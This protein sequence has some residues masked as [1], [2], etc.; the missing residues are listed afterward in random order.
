MTSPHIVENIN[1]SLSFAEGFINHISTSSGEDVQLSFTS[2]EFMYIG[3]MTVSVEI[4]GQNYL[5][6]M[7]WSK[8]GS[9][10]KSILSTRRQYWHYGT[11]LLEQVL[12][13]QKCFIINSSTR[14]I[15]ELNNYSPIAGL[16][17][18]KLEEIKE[19][20]E[21]KELIVDGNEE[22]EDNYYVQNTGQTPN[23]P[24]LL[25]DMII[26]NSTDKIT[27]VTFSTNGE[28]LC[29][30]EF[31]VNTSE[32]K[33]LDI[34]VE[35]ILQ[36]FSKAINLPVSLN[37]Y[38]IDKLD[39]ENS[40]IYKSKDT[41][42]LGQNITMI[43]ARN[44][45]IA[46]S[47]LVCIFV[48]S[49]YAF[50]QYTG[51]SESD[52]R[53]A[54]QR[55]IDRIAEQQRVEQEKRE[56]EYMELARNFLNFQLAS[57]VLFGANGFIPMFMKDLKIMPWIITQNAGI[58]DGWSMTD[59][60]CYPN[61][62]EADF[63]AMTISISC[64]V[65]YAG[66]ER[67]DVGFLINKLDSTSLKGRYTLQ[68]EFKTNSTEVTFGYVTPLDD[69]T[70]VLRASN[71]EAIRFFEELKALSNIKD[72]EYI[73]E[74]KSVYDVRGQKNISEGLKLLN[75]EGSGQILFTLG[76]S[77]S[78]I[79]SLDI[80]LPRNSQITSLTG[81]GMNVQINGAYNYVKK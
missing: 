21:F 29:P 3:K 70:L 13:D 63:N 58:K 43:R 47:I 9:Y 5:S 20:F 6:G 33:S 72:F 71:L 15:K 27:L 22:E 8:I 80:E 12:G 60:G 69:N 41:K 25:G 30:L 76:S 81:Q 79:T 35:S 24:E 38:E 4:F 11:R 19:S 53:I 45:K 66:E 18:S 17:F 75:E 65:K 49:S 26:L 55:K 23:A 64:K 62:T 7:E 40:E 48:T 46:L 39:L 73:Y 56:N 31:S 28:V 42:E 50:F 59:W 68:N 67:S 10:P 51:E 36:D 74:D 61:P 57:P 44:R 14:R 32:R 54:K 16:F 37:L 78:R 34:K 52:K 1:Q 2:Q 77:L